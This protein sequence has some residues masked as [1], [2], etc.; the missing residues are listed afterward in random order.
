MYLCLIVQFEGTL[1]RL[2]IFVFDNS[3][4]MKPVT[5]KT[6]LFHY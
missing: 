1:S 3:M 5:G 2:K 6:S 4:M